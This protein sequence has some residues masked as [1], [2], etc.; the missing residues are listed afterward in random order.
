MRTDKELRDA[1]RLFQSV[2]GLAEN[3]DMSDENT[4]HMIQKSRCG[5]SDFGPADKA[6]RRRRYALQGTKWNKKVLLRDFKTTYLM[7]KSITRYR[8]VNGT[9]GKTKVCSDG[10]LLV[11][12]FFL[13][14][15]KK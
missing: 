9:C 14:I 5:L 6:R 12:L 7:S 8:V 15:Y 10:M 11:F 3:G 4:L 1:V 13:R 2:A